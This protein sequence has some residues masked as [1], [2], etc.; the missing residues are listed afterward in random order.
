M[1][2]VSLVKGSTD[3]GIPGMV[4][5]AVDLIGG[6]E[7][8]IDGGDTV[9]LKPNI[10]TGKLSGPGVTTDPRIVEAVIT[11][12]QEAGAGEALVVEGS[13]YGVPTSEA[14]EMAGMKG[15]AQRNGAGLVDVDMDGVVE[16]EVPDPLILD[17]IP[18][19]RSF[20]NADVKINLPVMKTHDQLLMTL[21]MKNM[22]GVIQKPTKRLFHRI[23]LAKAVVDLN[24]AVPLDLTVVDAIHAME[25]L[26]PSYG[27]VFEMDM[28]MASTDVYALDVVGAWV[29]GIEPRELEY[30]KYATGQGLVSLDGTGIEV[31]GERVEAVSR[32]FERPPMDL[33]PREGVT[34]IEAGACSACRGTIR[35]VYHDLENMEVMDR[36]QG[37]TMLVGPHA[38]LP[39]DLEGAP[40]IMGVCLQH[41]KD[42]GRYV[43]GCPPNN[44][45]MREAIMEL[46]GIEP[47]AG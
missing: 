9:A 41:L 39:E 7:Q 33:S 3:Q 42:E 35:S 31:L 34:V 36:V 45:K 15:V 1:S 14:L 29:M 38:E 12:V 40:L 46:S 23:G 44:D 47:P 26:G 16:V 4:R 18:V 25:G 22:K 17:R 28:V 32:R 21:G 20:Y 27:N 11:L 8:I 5:K 43:V 24:K 6:F 37:L 30:L 2:K 19:S 13:G 10:L